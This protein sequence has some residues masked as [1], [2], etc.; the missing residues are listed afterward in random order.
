LLASIPILDIDINCEKMAICVKSST[1]N[2]YLPKKLRKKGREKYL[3]LFT[4]RKLSI[5]SKITYI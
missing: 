2:Y 1:F 4:N 3:P 5:Y